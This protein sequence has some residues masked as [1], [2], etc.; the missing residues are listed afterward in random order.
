MRSGRCSYDAGRGSVLMT[1]M[2]GFATI[3][4]LA[5]T[6]MVEAVN[7]GPLR[8]VCSQLV[9][10]RPAWLH[11]FSHWLIPNPYEDSGPATSAFMARKSSQRSAKKYCLEFE[12]EYLYAHMSVL[13]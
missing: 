13:L 8:G 5:A 11:R 1:S 12:K 6:N 7:F 10:K 3:W 2:V 4:S 9:K